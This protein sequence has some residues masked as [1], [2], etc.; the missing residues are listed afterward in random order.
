MTQ[1]RQLPF[2]GSQPAPGLARLP[3]GG[4]RPGL[5]LVQ[6]AGLQRVQ[7][8]D[9]GLRCQILLLQYVL[10]IQYNTEYDGCTQMH[11]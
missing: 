8:L 3:V 7:Q 6:L 5:Q 2:Q 4:L 9:G 1:R 11:T 10:S